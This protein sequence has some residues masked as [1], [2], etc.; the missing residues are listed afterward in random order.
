[1]N[2][3]IFEIFSDTPVA[4]S[5]FLV[6]IAL[7]LYT[8]FKNQSLMYQLMLH[9]F[10]FSKGERIYT[11]ITSGFVH[12]DIGH[13]LF[14]SVTFFFFAF[15]LERTVGSF[16]F[17]LIYFLSLILSD[18]PTI[19]RN[20]NNPDYR[21]LGASGAISG[22]LFSFIIFYPTT[23]ISMLLFPIGIPAYLF[24][25]L[26]TV[27][28]IWADKKGWGNI[29]HNAHLWGGLIGFGLTAFLYP[30]YFFEFIGLFTNM[31]N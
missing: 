31:F 14:N 15:P 21:S 29:N 23:P 19:I 7:S 17:F 24:A 6:F 30:N 5:V 1:M 27:Y 20:R 4:S 3:A 2:P 9:P 12:A 11:I 18:V 25:V 26:Y 13:L 16:A 22:V 28:C 8:M 10:S